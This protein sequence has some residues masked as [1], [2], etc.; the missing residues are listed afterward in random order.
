[1]SRCYFF[2]GLQTLRANLSGTS[3]TAYEVAL[4]ITGRL[5]P[6]LY[7]AGLTAIR[8]LKNP[9]KRLL[10]IPGQ[11]NSLNIPP[12]ETF[13]LPVFSAEHQIALFGIIRSL[14]IAAKRIAR[15]C[16]Y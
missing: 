3:K 4:Y 8:R 6:Y 11:P 14:R 1:M 9:Q 13:V 12:M 2:S 7:Q 15:I 16:Q 10:C 5:A